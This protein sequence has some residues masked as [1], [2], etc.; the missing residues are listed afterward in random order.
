MRG[1]VEGVGGRRGEGRR[2]GPGLAQLWGRGGRT[3]GS[4]PHWSLPSGSEAMRPNMDRAAWQ[5]GD[6][7]PLARATGS[8][9]RPHGGRE[10]ATP[11]ARRSGIFWVSPEP[12]ILVCG[13]DPTLGS[14]SSRR[15]RCR[16]MLVLPSLMG[17]WSSSLSLH[18]K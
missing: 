6:P 3:T 9:G 12:W 18:V 14:Q 17:L 13:R 7:S 10:P 16:H 2:H 11:S 5:H 15:A 4:V 8:P 1:H